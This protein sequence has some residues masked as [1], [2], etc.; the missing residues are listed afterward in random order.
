VTNGFLFP[1][2]DGKNRK[3]GYVELSILSNMNLEKIQIILLPV[4]EVYDYY[5]KN[6]KKM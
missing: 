2:Y 5:L 6:K 3:K 1:K 4:N